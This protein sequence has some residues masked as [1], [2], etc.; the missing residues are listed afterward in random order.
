MRRAALIMVTECFLAQSEN[1]L[2]YLGGSLVKPSRVLM[3]SSRALVSSCGRDDKASMTTDDGLMNAVQPSQIKPQGGRADQR[4]G[5]KKDYRDS[6]NDKTTE[7]V[8]RCK[9]TV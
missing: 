9:M 1:N 5:E 4:E 3:K 8:M 2:G 6:Q 7:K